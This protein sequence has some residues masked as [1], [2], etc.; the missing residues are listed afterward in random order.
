MLRKLLVW[1][2]LDAQR[3]ADGQDFEQEGELFAIF[4]ADLGRH[5]SFV[6]LND[7]EERTLSLDILRWQ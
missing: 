2:G 4:I 5:E 7:V 6:V 1:M 3:L